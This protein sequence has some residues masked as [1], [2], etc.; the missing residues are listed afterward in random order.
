[1]SDNS[2]APHTVQPVITE[3]MEVDVEAELG[4]LALN[5]GEG[6]FPQCRNDSGLNP[7]AMMKALQ[8]MIDARFIGEYS[9]YACPSTVDQ[10]Y[11]EKVF[12]SILEIMDE[13]VV[14]EDEELQLPELFDEQCF[15]ESM[16]DYSSSESEGTD[17]DAAKNDPKYKPERKKRKRVDSG[18]VP[19]ERKILIVETADK[20]PN[21]S[22]ETLKKKGSF[23]EITNRNSVARY[24]KQVEKKT[25]LQLCRE[26]D[27]HVLDQVKECRKTFKIL[28]A[29]HLRIFAMQKYI[30]LNTPSFIFKASQSWVTKFKKR[31]RISSRKITKLVSRREIREEE[32]ILESA[33]A[34]QSDIL[35]LSDKFNPDDIVNTD[36]CGWQYEPPSARTY[37]FKGEKQVFG[38]AESPKNKVTHSYTVQYVISMEGNIKGNVFVC[39]QEKGGKLGP[40]VKRV[41]ESNLPKNVTITCSTSGKMS[42]SL[43]EYFIEQQFVPNLKNN[44]VCIVDSWGG[45][46]QI[47][48]YEKFFGKSL[49][50]PAITLKIVPEK[51][52]PIVQP[53]DTYFHRQLKYL[54]KEIL[55]ALELFIPISSLGV[56]HSTTTRMGVIK[57]QSLLHFQL[58]APIFKPMIRYCWYSSGLTKEKED[59]LNVKQVCFNFSETDPNVCQME[60]CTN[61]RFLK[62]AHCRLGICLQH[63]WVEAHMNSCRSSPFR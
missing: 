34:F 29:S 8:S 4:N 14:E 5:A 58:I 26:I 31:H 33:R 46:N 10:L 11:A 36:Q 28:R 41:V 23:P 9:K 18:E 22:W 45:H 44:F 7:F 61:V 12:D 17:D 20:K 6:D 63:L 53:L 16:S 57:L 1:L 59:F 37:T 13:F 49:S 30:Q 39:L 60:N 21:W 35:A 27:Q 48:S 47:G 38:C 50:R 43:N 40:K 51:C 54:G 55:A 56:E 52:T 15:P 24:R 2:S 3:S 62:C 32:E 19:I 25:R 42:T